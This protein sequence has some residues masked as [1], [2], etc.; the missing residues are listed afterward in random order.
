[1][2]GVAAGGSIGGQVGAVAQA[3]W[4]VERAGCAV[5]WALGGSVVGA[6][7]HCAARVIACRGALMRHR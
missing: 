5:V 3:R 1:M 4:V 2:E 6:V 7:T